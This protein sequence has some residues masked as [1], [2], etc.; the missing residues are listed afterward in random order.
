M[1]AEGGGA[2]G[3]RFDRFDPGGWRWNVDAQEAFHDPSATEDRGSGRAVGRNA[4]D[5]GL[6]EESATRRV[7]GKIDASW[8]GSFQG[9]QFVVIGEALV[10]EG[11]VGVDEIADGEIVVDE[12][13]E[14]HP[15]LEE[16]RFGEEIV[17]IVVG[18]EFGVGGIEV[19]LAEVEPVVEKGVGEVM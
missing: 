18:V 14:E 5:A 7:G 6:G 13:L 19:D 12:M 1:L 3:V 16:G 15:G 17:Q 11:E 9:A 2:A 8:F 10:E 4:E